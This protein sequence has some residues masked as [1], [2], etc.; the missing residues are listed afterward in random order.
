MELR[1]RDRPGEITLV[2]LPSPILIAQIL[3]PKLLTSQLIRHESALLLLVQRVRPI[4]KH[5]LAREQIAPR[6]RR[7]TAV[8]TYWLPI[9]QPPSTLSCQINSSN[10]QCSHQEAHKG[11]KA[12][13]HTPCSSHHV[14]FLCHVHLPFASDWGLVSKSQKLVGGSHF[15]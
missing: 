5:P 14:Q 6:A 2:R 9:F 7:F 12:A 11:M 4:I 10:N 3:P 1:E 15:F 13:P 8:L